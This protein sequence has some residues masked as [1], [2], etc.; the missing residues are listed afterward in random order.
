MA[1]VDSLLVFGCIELLGS[2]SS[3]TLSRVTF[4]SPSLATTTSL[5][6]TFQESHTQIRDP[7]LWL[8]R[9][10]TTL[11]GINYKTSLV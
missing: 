4:S 9:L 1:M 3:L 2:L 7:V 6:F 5:A 11:D 8:T 10:R